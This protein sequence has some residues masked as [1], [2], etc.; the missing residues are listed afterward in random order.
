MT[1]LNLGINK[2]FD[3]CTLEQNEILVII[4][5]F[6]NIFLISNLQGIFGVVHTSESILRLGEAIWAPKTLQDSLFY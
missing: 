5:E 2:N 3:S 6:T 1:S 4:H